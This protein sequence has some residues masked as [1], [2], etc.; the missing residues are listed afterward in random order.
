MPITMDGVT[1][2]VRVKYNSLEQ[3]FRLEDGPNAGTMMSGLRERDLLGT[4]YDY[5]LSVEP[6]PAKLEDYNKFFRAISAPVPSHTIVLPDGDGTLTFQAMVYSGAHRF[7]GTVGGTPRWSGL[8]VLFE[9]L[10]PLRTPEV[11][12]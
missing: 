3:S 1:Y 6:D 7:K 9:S 5:S 2:Q 8:T 10:K 12:L 11:G 4:Y